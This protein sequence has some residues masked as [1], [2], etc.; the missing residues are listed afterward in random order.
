[1]PIFNYVGYK[2][3][4]SQIKGSLEASGLNDATFAIRAL[5]VFP[6][7]IIQASISYKKRR[8][9]KTDEAFLP[10]FTRQLSIL[11]S[12]G[13]PLL[14]ALQT[15]ASEKRLGYGNMIVTLKERVAG[16]ASL[17]R[18]M[19]DFHNYFPEYF[20]NMVHAGEQSGNLDD[21]LHRLAQYLENYAA[22]RARVRSALVYPVFMVGVSFV[23]MSFLFTFVIPKILKMFTDTQSTLPFLTEV[24]VL[25]SH[26]FT[27]FWWAMLIIC[28]AATLL[29]RKFVIKHRRFADRMILKLPGNIIQALYY[30]RFARTLSLLINGGLPMIAS[31]RL[32]AKSIGNK[33][34]ETAVLNA[35]V[36]IAEGQ[37][38]SSALQMFPPTFIQLIATGE[39]TGKLDMT[40]GRAAEAYEEEF[41][42]NVESLISIFEPLLIIIMGFVVGFI[43][44]AT[45][46]PMFEL[47][48]LI[49]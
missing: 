8:L 38:I 34:L 6:A 25:I 2:A 43:V 47:N 27:E 41:K 19:E 1:M 28:A 31:L 30:A 48:Q 16:G 39:K 40:L 20:T 23:I 3:D 24:L 22:I 44:I 15:L 37:N 13:V 9:W 11:L 42:R 32:A 12:S 14:D 10:D 5:G 7:E 35:E 29:C 36:R 4:G 17:S 18:A 46:L 26:I 33:E 21:V 45:L 49:R